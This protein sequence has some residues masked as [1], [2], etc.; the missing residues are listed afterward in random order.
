MERRAALGKDLLPEGYHLRDGLP[1]PESAKRRA[2]LERRFGKGRVYAARV[3]PFACEDLNGERLELLTREL[4]EE[5][6]VRVQLEEGEILDAY[7]E[8]ATLSHGTARA[9]DL[10]GAYA[11]FLEELGVLDAVLEEDDAKDARAI[12]IHGEDA[13][14]SSAERAF[15]VQLA[16]HEALEALAPEGYSFGSHE[17]DGSLVGFWADE[18]DEEGEPE[19]AHAQEGSARG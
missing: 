15:D 8:P 11:G 9:V 5:L 18:E 3:S 13:P 12:A 4:A 17:G 1:T 10:V 7:G 19:H 16:L 14:G 6:R 2:E